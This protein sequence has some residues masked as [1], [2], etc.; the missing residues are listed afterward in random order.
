MPDGVPMNPIPPLLTALGSNLRLSPEDVGECL[1][2]SMVNVR[3]GEVDTRL[4]D[5]DNFKKCNGLCRVR[6]G[7]GGDGAVLGRNRSPKSGTVCK[8]YF[9]EVKRIAGKTAYNYLAN[10]SNAIGAGVV[11]AGPLDD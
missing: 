4:K 10:A 11:D 8:T 1:G 9:D 6:A 7:S 3:I 2:A 5:V